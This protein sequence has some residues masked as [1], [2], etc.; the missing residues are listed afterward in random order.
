MYKD[1][2]KEKDECILFFKIVVQ[3]KIYEN[4]N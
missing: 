4:D 2:V 1:D 3:W